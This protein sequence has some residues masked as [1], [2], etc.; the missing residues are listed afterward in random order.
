[1]RLAEVANDAATKVKIAAADR[2]DGRGTWL[3]F[4]FRTIFGDF[5][6]ARE[7]WT[8]VADVECWNRKPL[9]RHSRR[10]WIAG[11]NLRV[12]RVVVWSR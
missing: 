5:E 11:M 12:V 2:H 9:R 6:R 8:A 3:Y 10:S 1:M 7:M 4:I